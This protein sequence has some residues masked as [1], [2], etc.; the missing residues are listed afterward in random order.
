V[1]VPYP[2]LFG[3]LERARRN[4]AHDAPW[5]RFEPAAL[6]EEQALTVNM[7]AIAGCR[8]MGKGSPPR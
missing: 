6:E 1:H 2:E 7:N 4:I 5:A 8:A 3:S